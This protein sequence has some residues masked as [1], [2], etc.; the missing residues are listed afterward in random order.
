MVGLVAVVV[1]TRPWDRPDKPTKVDLVSP[2]REGSRVVKG[3]PPVEIVR[4]PATYRVVY[5]VENEGRKAVAYSTDKLYVR[6][7]WESRV[8]SWSAKPPGK[9]Q[10]A[11]EVGRFAKRVNQ[12][13][14]DQEPSALELPPAVP[15]SDVRLLPVLQAALDSGVLVRREVRE[16]ARRKCQVFRSAE[17]LNSQVLKPP[18]KNAY[19]DSCIDEAGIVLEELLVAKGEILSRRVAVEVEEDPVIDDELFPDAASSIPAASGGGAVRKV[20]AGS[21]PPGEFFVLDSPPEGFEY[22]GR[23]SVIPPQADNFSDPTREGARRAG[24]S[25]VWR[26]GADVLIVD[27]GGTLRGEAPFAIEADSQKIDLGQF[28]EGE[29]RLSAIT[30]EVRALQGQGRY[31]RVTGTLSTDELAAVAKALRPVA[32][33]TLG[34]EE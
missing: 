34:L 16:V 4:T 17:F 18:D 25:D 29:V 26:R 28:G 32:G 21:T 33:G 22:V 1:V 7:P 15:S 14:E 27:Q 13:G 24:I 2:G 11:L 9:K 31:I 30:N 20:K 3:A 23:Y 19:A 5:R 6:R 12:S 10:Q 8:E